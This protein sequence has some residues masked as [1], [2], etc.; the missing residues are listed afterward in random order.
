ML[1]LR[2]AVLEIPGVSSSAQEIFRS[3]D[4]LGDYRSIL[5]EV[6]E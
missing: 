1:F 5:A 4:K 2:S 3:A 6:F